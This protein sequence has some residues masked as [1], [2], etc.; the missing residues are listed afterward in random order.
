VTLHEPEFQ[1]DVLSVLAGDHREVEALFEQLDR[2]PPGDGARRDLVNR[3]TIEL[4]RHSVAEE[5]YL[6]PTVRRLL[7]GGNR[8][9]DMEMNEHA[10]AE[11]LLKILQGLD[12]A[13]V[14]FDITLAQL[15]TEM[16]DHMR[17]EEEVLFPKV[18][19]AALRE[20]LLELGRNLEEAR[21]RA[22]A[23]QHAG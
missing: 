23:H 15:M 16:Y 7:R 12:V 18:R 11:E 6:H 14:E 20:E 9:A 3:V 5:V 2:L 13:C 22:P 1:R 17:D 10:D 4:V 8:M 19:R 21:K